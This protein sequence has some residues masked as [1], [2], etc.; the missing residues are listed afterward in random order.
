[1]AAPYVARAFCDYISK[2]PASVSYE[3]AGALALSVARCMEGIRL[4]MG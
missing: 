4:A 1:M 3:E 2:K